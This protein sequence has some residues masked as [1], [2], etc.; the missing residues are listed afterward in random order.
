MSHQTAA[1]NKYM[2]RSK[3]YVN[4]WVNCYVKLKNVND[5]PKRDSTQKMMKKEDK[6]IIRMFANNTRLSLRDA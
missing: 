2:K 4:K 5:L 3:A 6:L 1:N